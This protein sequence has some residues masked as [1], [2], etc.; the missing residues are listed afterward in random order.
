MDGEAR[1][2]TSLKPVTSGAQSNTRGRRIMLDSASGSARPLLQPGMGIVQ[3]RS[4]S[5]HWTALESLWR[6]G[7]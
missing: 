2:P 3:T 1:R 5:G 4:P 7:G 6:E